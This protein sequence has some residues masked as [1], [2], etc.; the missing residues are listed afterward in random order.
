MPLRWIAEADIGRMLGDYI[1]T[2][3]VR[4]RPVPVLSFASQPT[5]GRFKQA[6]YAATRVTTP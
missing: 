5:G 3:F 2:S 6:I 1:S 4:G